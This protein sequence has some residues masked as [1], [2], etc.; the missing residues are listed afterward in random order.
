MRIVALLSSSLLLAACSAHPAGDDANVTTMMEGESTHSDAPTSES[1]DESTTTAETSTDSESESESEGDG[2]GDEGCTEP[3]KLDIPSDREAPM[4]E[5]CTVEWIPW[6][7]PEQYPGCEICEIGPSC[8]FDA[9]LG[10][11]TPAVGETCAD[12][13]PSGDCLGVYWDACEGESG[14]GSPYT[15]CGHYEIDGQ[16]CTIGKFLEYCAE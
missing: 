10:C 2:D 5:S 13:C 1:T 8:A 11:V 15:T 16:C 12:I 14:A 6:P 9:Y 3:I 4:P 7:T